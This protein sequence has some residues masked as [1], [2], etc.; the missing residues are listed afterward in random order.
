M[1]PYSSTRFSQFSKLTAFCVTVSLS[2]RE[3]RSKIFTRHADVNC[4]T[5]MCVAECRCQRVSPVLTT[6]HDCWIVSSHVAV[7]CCSS[8]PTVDLCADSQATCR[9]MS[10]ILA[11]LSLTCT[12]VDSKLPWQLNTAYGGRVKWQQTHGD[13]LTGK[14]SFC[15]GWNLLTYF[16]S[17][18]E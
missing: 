10:L 9:P 6:V 17:W 15:N 4:E 13:P 14:W 18:A 1:L 5:C 3:E 12:V 11:D 8:L 2:V 16:Q 7:S